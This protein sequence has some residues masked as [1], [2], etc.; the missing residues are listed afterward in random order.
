MIP[1]RSED[2]SYPAKPGSFRTVE[3][4][5]AL[6][7]DRAQ[8]GLRVEGRGRD[9]HAGAV[10]HGGEVAHHHAEAVVEGH[11][12]ADPVQ[13]RVLAQ[14]TDEVTVV[15]DVPV[16]QGGA[17]G[18]AGGARGV[19]DVDRVTRGE[20]GPGGLQQAAV[21][22]APGG[23]QRG[24]GLLADQYRVA[25]LRAG[26]GGRGQHPGVVG[27]LERGHRHDRPHP[28][29]LQHELQLVGPVSG[30]DGDQD[31][32]DP[33][34]GEL[35]EDPLGAVGRPDAHPVTAPHAQCQ[36]SQRHRVHLVGQFAVAPAASGDGV[37]QCLA[38][39]VGGD[40]AVQGGADGLVQ[41]GAVG[42]T[43]GSAERGGVAGGG[44]GGLLGVVVCGWAAR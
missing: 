23:G 6:G 2:R 21:G 17:L 24:P 35:E 7:G 29:L 9:H 27:G 16:R 31:R 43:G 14:L 22:G 13:L 37:H 40:G 5:A 36:Q 33:G 25:Q 34:G 32:A 8:G 12:D 10:R 38:P 28:G 26:G 44:H 41:Q 3:R 42:G 18:E 30:V 11:R 39:A 20:P 4:G 1:V 19:L 15:E